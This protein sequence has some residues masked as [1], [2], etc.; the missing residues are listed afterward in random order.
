MSEKLGTCDKWGEPHER[1]VIFAP[2]LDLDIENHYCNWQPLPTPSETPSDLVLAYGPLCGDICPVDRSIE[3]CTCGHESGHAGKHKC[4]GC[5]FEWESPNP[6]A[7]MTD[8]DNAREEWNFER[9]HWN[10]HG[11][12]FGYDKATLALIN[13]LE[14]RLARAE[15]VIAKVEAYLDG[16][17]PEGMSYMTSFTRRAFIDGVDAS[18]SVVRAILSEANK[19][20]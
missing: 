17:M 8:L 20:A 15:G 13:A 16:P 3:H 7:A 12:S 1:V 9:E 5:P 18:R 2:Q 4:Y 14:A 11:P 19:G 10:G 6:I